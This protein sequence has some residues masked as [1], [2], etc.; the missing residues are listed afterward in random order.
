VLPTKFYGK[1]VN[2]I[3]PQKALK[4]HLVDE[5][6]C[7][8]EPFFLDQQGEKNFHSAASGANPSIRSRFR[9]GHLDW[10]SNYIGGFVSYT[11]E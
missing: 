11:R 1:N 2:S 6:D 8:K 5:S 7:K 10:F 9:W 3:P 4:L